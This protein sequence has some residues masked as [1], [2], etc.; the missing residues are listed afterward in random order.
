MIKKIFLL[1]VLTVV[2]ALRINT[3]AQPMVQDFNIVSPNRTSRIEAGEVLTVK[4]TNY[5]YSARNIS[6]L[7]IYITKGDDIIY[8]IAEN[9]FNNGKYVTK[10]PSDFIPGQYRIKITSVDETSF[11]L[12]QEFQIIAQ[13][14]IK[15]IKPDSESVWEQGNDYKIKWSAK[16]DKAYIDLLKMTEDNK[17]VSRLRIADTIDNKGEYLW[18]IP[19]NLED[20]TYI[21]AIRI[22]PIKEVKHSVPF[23]IKK[24]AK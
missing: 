24:L 18:H 2:T 5:S 9:I 15:I 13:I 21:I 3:F 19:A 7:N 17:F 8:T 16:G 20:G 6:R 4:W 23:V 14:P 12:S 22:P 10:L 1:S 11:A